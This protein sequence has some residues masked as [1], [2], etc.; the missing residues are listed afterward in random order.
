MNFG[1]TFISYIK[2]L[3]NK[4]EAAC[5]NNGV[6]SEWFYLYRGVRQGCP[7]SPYL[8]IIVVELLSIA[9]KTNKDIK[10]IKIGKNRIHINQFADDTIILKQSN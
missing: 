4:V 6:S 2:L 10:G 8:F 9:L 7:I 3:K 5:L 1:A